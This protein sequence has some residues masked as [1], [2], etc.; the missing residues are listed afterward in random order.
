MQYKLPK[1][2]FELKKKFIEDL[3]G[4]VVKANDIRKGALIMT[5][6]DLRTLLEVNNVRES[7]Y[8]IYPQTG[9][10][11][12]CACFIQPAQTGGWKIFMEERGEVSDVSYHDTEEAACMRFLEE[13]FPRLLPLL[14]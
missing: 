4:V 1:K 5:V 7:N 3:S 8:V 14:K 2:I 9:T 11:S 6:Q 13:F 12:P 10:V